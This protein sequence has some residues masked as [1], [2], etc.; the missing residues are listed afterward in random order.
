MVNNL[1]MVQ[2]GLVHDTTHFK[3][4][5]RQRV[6]RRRGCV[7]FSETPLPGPPSPLQRRV[8]GQ[9]GAAASW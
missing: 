4:M 9:K 7:L 3:T 5:Q 6:T 1:Y 8:K 2:A